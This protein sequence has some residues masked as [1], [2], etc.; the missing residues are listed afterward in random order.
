[1]RVANDIACIGF[2]LRKIQQYDIVKWDYCNES[3]TLK[4]RLFN[5]Y[6]TKDIREYQ[7]IH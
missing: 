6:V 2:E 1:M 5:I 4:W 7:N 3:S